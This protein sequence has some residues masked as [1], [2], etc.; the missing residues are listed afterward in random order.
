LSTGNR[1]FDIVVGPADH[2]GEPVVVGAGAAGHAG[3]E[4]HRASVNAYR[5]QMTHGTKGNGGQQHDHQA[6][7]SLGQQAVFTDQH[8][9][10]LL[11]GDH[12][13][14]DHIADTSNLN[15]RIQLRWNAIEPTCGTL[16]CIEHRG[17]LTASHETHRDAAAD[18]AESDDSGTWC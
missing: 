16:A 14:Q 17:Y 7:V 5:S 11:R 9:L 18:H 2:Y 6:G 4:E 8:T 3:V 1:S 12:G 10:N 15:R 13:N